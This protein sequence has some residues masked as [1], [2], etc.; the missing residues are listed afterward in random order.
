MTGGGSGGHITPLLSLARE[1]KAQRRDCQIVYIGHK[2]DQFDSLR[3]GSHDF[4]F[5]AFINAGKF[6]R[7][8]GESFFSHLFDVRTITLN[9]RDFFRVIK[10]IGTAYR[11]LARTQ[12]DVLFSKGGFVAVP[13]GIAA[14]LKGIPIITHDSDTLGGLAN[15]IVGRWATVHATG[16]PA[17]NYP[18]PKQSVRYVGIPLDEHIKPVTPAIQSEFKEAIGI[19]KQSLLILV[20]GGGN[21]SKHLNDMVVSL[22]PHLLRTNLAAYVVHLTGSKNLE[23]VKD[24]Y[25]RDLDKEQLQRVKV[26]DFANDLY[27][28][29]AAA[30]LIISRAGATAIAEYAVQGKACIIIP[31][32]FLAGGHQLGNARALAEQDAAAIV[33]EKATPK[34]LLAVIDQLLAD[35]HRRWELSENIK[36]TA[37]PGAAKKLAEIVLEVTGK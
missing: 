31:S 14:R 16:T 17:K 22:A 8:H 15:R 13:V 5:M 36:K 3:A 10:S 1:L 33:E 2:G 19:P 7:Y 28:Y 12:P 6:R 29:S 20:T 9:I 21:G 23:A 18:Y 34:E 35:D 37:K 27:K 4:D 32:P 30:D 25:A 26:M 11:V 24:G